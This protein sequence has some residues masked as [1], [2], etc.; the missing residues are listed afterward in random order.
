MCGVN[1]LF[2][3]ETL[4]ICSMH[5]TRDTTERNNHKYPDQSLLKSELKIVLPSKINITTIDT[6][7]WNDMVYEKNNKPI[8]TFYM[9]KLK[10]FDNN[11]MLLMGKLSSERDTSNHIVYYDGE[12]YKK[13]IKGNPYLYGK[14]FWGEDLKKVIEDG[15]L[16]RGFQD[17]CVTMIVDQIEAYYDNRIRIAVGVFDSTGITTKYLSLASGVTEH[18]KVRLSCSPGVTV[19]TASP[20]VK[21]I[22]AEKEYMFK[23]H[24]AAK[25]GRLEYANYVVSGK[26]S[27]VNE[28]LLLSV[29]CID[30][31]TGR[32]ITA[33]DALVDPINGHNVQE[34]VNNLGDKIRKGIE[35]D[36]QKVLGYNKRVAIVPIPPFP[37]TIDNIRFTREIL[38]TV[39]AAMQLAQEKLQITVVNDDDYLDELMKEPRDWAVVARE[40]NV[41]YIIAIRSIRPTPECMLTFE[42]YDVNDLKAKPS[43]KYY[44]YSHIQDLRSGLGE[45]IAKFT[46]HTKVT[47]EISKEAKDSAKNIIEGVIFLPDLWGIRA[48]YGLIGFKDESKEV[49]MDTEIRYYW[50]VTLISHID[51]IRLEINYANDKGYQTNNGNSVDGIY[52][53]PTIKVSYHIPWNDLIIR[54][55]LDTRFYIGAGWS[56]MFVTVNKDDNIYKGY[57]N[58]VNVCGGLDVPLAVWRRAIMNINLQYYFPLN[59]QVLGITEDGLLSWNGNLKSFN[60]SLGLEYRFGKY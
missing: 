43:P 20:D 58:G 48:R 17:W 14:L 37:K 3:Q 10:E 35:I 52:L 36:Y 2:S 40:L 4:I 31:E 54:L 46:S 51:W 29:V 44:R 5:D 24:T 28:S 23:Q 22:N 16:K 33:Y 34:A 7:V 41:Q 26:I 27:E 50:D 60:M 18:I 53:S 47:S 8:D 6:I 30:L 59:Y 42:F 32:I 25:I 49:Y 13:D 56:M 11:T 55:P 57:A 38:S 21:Y 19:I 9:A 12:L 1:N 15:N 45:Q 39:T